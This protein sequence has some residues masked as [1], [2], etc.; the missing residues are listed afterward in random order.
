[1]LHKFLVKSGTI[2]IM[3]FFFIV[4]SSC[5]PNETKKEDAAEEVPF[6]K[7]SLAQWSIHKQINDVGMDPFDFAKVAKAWGF[8]GLEYVNQLY[9]KEIDA[10]GFNAVIERL[11]KESEKHQIKN[12]LIMVDNEG[13]L[14]D[15]DLD[16]RNAAVENH[17]K[18]VDAA[19]I[20]GC[21]SI[22]VNAFGSNDPEIWKETFKDGLSKLSAY[23]ATKNINVLVENHGW[24]SSDAPKLMAVI[25]AVNRVNCGTLPDFGNW[26]TIRKGDEDWGECIEEYPDKYQGIQLMMA[27]AKAVSAKSYDFDTDGN[28][29]TID[30]KKMLEIINDAGYTGFIGVEYEGHR[31]SE[32]EGIL[33]T[34]KLLLS[35]A[36]QMH[37]Q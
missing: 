22:R 30:F 15:P 9:K 20:L 6:F 37:L 19:Q 8:D 18:W 31:L 23:A 27:H 17:K 32:E 11:K 33:A 4:L 34:K 25:N 1:M 24:L 29:T 12:L 26:C 36:K 16:I 14:S 35:A 13:D 10:L 7:L 2:L 21:H 5:K 28:E 3:S